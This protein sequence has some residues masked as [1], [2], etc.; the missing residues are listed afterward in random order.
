MPKGTQKTNREKKKP[1]K[2]KLPAAPPSPFPS[3]QRRTP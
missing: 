3:Q 2:E 1:K